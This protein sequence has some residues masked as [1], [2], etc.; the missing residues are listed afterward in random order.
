MQWKSRIFTIE[1]AI[2]TLLNEYNLEIMMQSDNLNLPLESL[3]QFNHRF[4]EDVDV[5]Y[6]DNK[7]I[8]EWFNGS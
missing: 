4:L 7:V 5:V 1:D 8:L 6:R 3:Y 2:V